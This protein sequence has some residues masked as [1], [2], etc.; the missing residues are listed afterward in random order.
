MTIEQIVEIPTDH[1][2]FFEFLAPKE[3]PPGTARVE[4]KFTPVLNAQDK[5]A[6]DTR[7]NLASSEDSATPLTDALSGILSHAGDISIE[8]IREE[9]L[10]A[11]YLK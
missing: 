3:L 11:K 10:A 9:R 4:L 6:P 5:P 1:R 8:Q 2:V 7:K